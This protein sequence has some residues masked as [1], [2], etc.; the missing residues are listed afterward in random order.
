MSPEHFT[1]EPLT[2]ASDQFSL[3]VLGYYLVTGALPF[4][5]QDNPEVRRRNFARGPAPAHEEAAQ[6]TRPA[7]PGAVSRVLAT[8]LHTSQASRY[9]SVQEFADD[10]I[11][12]F[13][14]G[15]VVGKAKGVF[16]SYNRVDS[17][18]WATL[19]ERELKGQ[20]MTV[21]MDTGNELRAGEF[22]K[23]LVSHIDHCDVFVCLLAGRTLKSKWVREE[24]QV[25]HEK[26]KPMI[27]IFQE[28]FKRPK[29][30]GL[31]DPAIGAL[32]AHQG[33]ELMDKKNLYIQAALEQ[34]VLLIQGQNASRS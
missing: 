14:R 6:N 9:P 28:S 33:V 30:D 32:L 27:P 16:L 1:G 13:G 29:A 10:L 7:V 4:V 34:L 23:Q 11:R 12:A 31:A 20:G 19:V 18:G 5:G 22:S 8:A 24:I 15:T 17:A 26:G 25:A 3:A 21:F 2:P